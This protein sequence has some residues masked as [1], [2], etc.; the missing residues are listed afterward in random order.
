MPT[1]LYDPFP[2]YLQIRGIIIHW[3]ATLEIGARL[4]TEEVLADK[5]KVSRETIREALLPLGEDGTLGRRPRI[6]TWLVKHPAAALDRRL[7]GPFEN[8]AN[9]P[10]VKIELS[11]AIQGEID[12]TPDVSVV[13]KLRD[14]ERVYRFQRV[15]TYEGEPIVVLDAIFPLRIGR[16][17]ATRNLSE[18]F[19]LPALRSA[20]DNNIYEQFQQIEAVSPSGTV[21]RSLKV[22]RQAPV[23]LVKRI[24]VDGNGKPV[25]LFNSYFRSDSYYYTVNLPKMRNGT[26]ARQAKTGRKVR[27]SKPGKKKLLRKR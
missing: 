20:V 10:G 24:F 3:L 19:F 14:G 9:L 27:T 4:P 16:K 26:G 1:P 25:G 8:F 2:K 7:T 18:V 22:D 23:L 13:L 15:R 11:S 21:A 6:G 17:L 5:F 12:A